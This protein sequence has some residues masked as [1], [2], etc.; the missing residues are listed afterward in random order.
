MAAPVIFLLVVTF[1]S[2]MTNSAFISVSVLKCRSKVTRPLLPWQ[3][4]VVALAQNF[5]W[6]DYE[7]DDSCLITIDVELGTLI[8]TDFTPLFL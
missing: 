8:D 7:Y 6:S 1:P 2:T 3:L 5:L 4:V